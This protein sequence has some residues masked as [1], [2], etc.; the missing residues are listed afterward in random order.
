MPDTQNTQKDIFSKVEGLIAFL[1]TTDEKKVREN[2]QEWQDLIEALRDIQNNPIPFLLGLLKALQE[3]KFGQNVTAK[4]KGFKAARKKKRAGKKGDDDFKETK[5]SF[6]EKHLKD[7]YANVW[8]ATLNKLIKNAVLTVLPRVKD[9]FV[10]EIIKAFNCDLTTLVPV[11]GDGLSGPVVIEV[12]EIDLLKQLFND[13]NPAPPPPAEPNSAAKYMYE[14]NGLN[15]GAY[16]VGTSPYP[17]NRFLRD[18]IYNNA[19]LIGNGVPAAPNTIRTIYGKSGKA[20]FDVEV[21]AVLGNPTILKI[22]PY[23]KTEVGN[24]QF[25]N[26]PGCNGTPIAAPGNGAKFTFIDFL[27]DYFNNIELIELQNLAGALLEILTGFMSTTNEAFSIQDSKHLQWFVGFV[28]NVLKACDGDDLIGPNSESIGH[29]AE[30]TD[31]DN[32]FNFTVEEERAMMLEVGRKQNN[33]LTLQSC[34]SLDIPID[35]SM[36]D[37]AVDDMLATQVMEEKLQI[38]DLLLQK[39]ARSSAKKAGYDLGLGTISLPVEID[40][41]ENILKKLP[42]ILMYCI[43]NP[44]AVLPLV[45]TGKVLNQNGQLCSSIDLF[46]KVFKRVIIRVIKEILQEV[47]KEIMKMVKQYLLQKIRELI[48]RKLSEQAKKRIRMIR[49]LL[50]LLLPLISALNNAKNCQE[51]Y[52]I[53]LG[54]LMANMPDMPFKVPAFLVAAAEMRAGTTALGTFERFLT[55]CQQDGIPIG[56]LPDGSPN[57]MLPAFRKAFEAKE[58]EDGDHKKVL[59]VIPTGQVITAFGPATI[60]PFTKVTGTVA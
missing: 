43:M 21:L 29:H 11:V 32:Y 37:A 44:K 25:A 47:T 5:K 53:L 34:G 22:Y 52:N 19:T 14:Q 30:L 2:T 38:F 8:L 36:V 59:G 46:A 7:N 51:I 20:L 9:I 50:D 13:P 3:T 4:V 31:E 56:D 35:N 45:I 48:R 58:E 27:H 24:T 39:L 6:K 17:V 10:E 41:K 16:P 54:L 57:M 15:G 26:A 28:E 49:R 42:Q 1:D 23:Y 55:K 60:A 18:L 33:V 12:A 40:F